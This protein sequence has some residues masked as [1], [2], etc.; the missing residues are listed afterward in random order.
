MNSHQSKL[1]NGIIIGAIS[2]VIFITLLTIIGELFP[3]LKTLLKD[4]HHHHWVGKGIWA[5]ILFVIV[6]SVYYFIKKIDTSDSTTR[7]MRALAWTLI[8]SA[9]TL[10]LFFVY[11]FFKHQL[12][13]PRYYL[14]KVFILLRL[15]QHSLK[16]NH[17]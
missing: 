12:I 11:E 13:V 8:F 10:F 9:L 7:F 16:I 5:T 6:A 4:A 2:A 1:V 3:P 15:S 17:G 14:Q